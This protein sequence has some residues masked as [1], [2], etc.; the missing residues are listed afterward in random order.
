M[1]FLSETFWSISLLS[2]RCCPHLY[3]NI[4]SLVVLNASTG[5]YNPSKA[6]SSGVLQGPWLHLGHVATKGL[7]TQLSSHFSHDTIANMVHNFYQPPH[8]L[9][10]EASAAHQNMI[11]AT[12]S[13]GLS[14][15][16]GFRK[17]PQTYQQCDRCKDMAKALQRPHGPPWATWLSRTSDSCRMAHTHFTGRSSLIWSFNTAH[18]ADSPTDWPR[19]PFFP[20]LWMFCI[21]GLPLP[22]EE[23]FPLGHTHN[24]REFM[25]LEETFTHHP[26]LFSSLL[27][28]LAQNSSFFGCS[29]RLVYPYMSERLRGST[30]DP[31]LLTR[32]NSTSFC[33]SLWRGDRIQLA[34]NKVQHQAAVASSWTR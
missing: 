24:P 4:E 11:I 17:Q 20:K 26:Q 2:N 8:F 31:F 16:T 30:E 7:L 22:G 28:L 3:H 15:L 5:L 12:F 33:P 6:H 34:A 10:H 14:A 23:F 9:D 13:Q 18:R 19:P 1:I 32:T 29:V 21:G 25:K 27:K